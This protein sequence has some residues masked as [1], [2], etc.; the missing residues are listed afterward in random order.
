MPLKVIGAGFGRTGTLS[1]YAAL[2]QLG[3]PC[4]HMVEVLE[5]RANKSHLDFWHAVATAP[6]GA[7][8][9]WER[10][11]ARYTA[12]VDNPACC[13]W[14][15]LLEAYPDAKVI[16]T[17]HPGGPDAWYD[18]S[19]A[20]IYRMG[21]QWQ[22]KMLAR[23]VPFL[24]KMGEMTRKL[25]W[26]RAHRGTMEDRAQAIAHY[27]RHVEDVKATVPPERLL[28][29]SVDHGWKPLCDFLGAP[30]PSTPF[31]NV[32]DRADFQKRL[33]ALRYAAYGV[34]AGGALLLAGLVY[35]ATRVLG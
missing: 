26:E 33:A 12:A 7:P 15:E 34:I 11:F 14:R 27:L 5:N 9:D 30:A 32:N 8:H 3:Y 1:L 2:R 13:A 29:Y 23:I 16:L 17:T 21:E 20:T 28:M 4:Y 6:P 25:I 22:F 31:P 24:R 19:R 18:S 10:V 35:A